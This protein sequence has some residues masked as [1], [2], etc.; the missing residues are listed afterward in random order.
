MR[1]GLL[2]GVRVLGPGA[3]P[4]VLSELHDPMQTVGVVVDTRLPSEYSEF[5]HTLGRVPTRPV[6][7]KSLGAGVSSG[8]PWAKH[9]RGNAAL[10]WLQKSEICVR[11]MGGRAV[12]KCLQTLPAAFPR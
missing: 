3:V 6:P 8:L 9:H 10:L 4:Y 12:R 11:F 5:G 7:S 2:V 1:V